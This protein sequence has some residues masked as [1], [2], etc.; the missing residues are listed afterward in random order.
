MAQPTR[1]LF[2]AGEVSPFAQ[3]S[4]IADLTRTLAEQLQDAGDYDARIMMPCYG[5]ISERK[6]NLHE[7]IRLSGTDI[8]MGDE[9][10]ELTV[11]VASVPGVR[12]QVYFMDRDDYFNRKGIAVDED[13]EPFDD[14]SRRA[15]FFNR[16][17]LEMILKLRWGP[18]VIH[19]FGWI[20]SLI[21]LL[22]ETEYAE[23]ELVT[24]AKI[25][26]TPD[27][28]D[29][30]AALTPE[31]A[32]E[33]GLE[34]DDTDAPTLNEIGQ[35]YADAAIV[36]PNLDAEGDADRFSDDE[37]ERIDQLVALY[38]RMLSEVPA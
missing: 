21:P 22:R 37:D 12:L 25:V 8:P 5:S 7:V 26:Y 36:P 1:I 34:L 20:S 11:K 15:L 23:E 38:D 14:N 16:A 32:T 19:S 31:D 9:T 35:R 24:N 17:V 28:L 33:L 27:D 30:D 4:S 3:A 6:H 18:D 2:V 29:P 13:G 10:E